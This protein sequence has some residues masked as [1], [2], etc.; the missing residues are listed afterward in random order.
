MNHS[1]RFGL[2]RSVYS[3]LFGVALL[4]AGTALS[5]PKP[6]VADTCSKPLCR[7]GERYRADSNPR[8]TTGWC[9]SSSGFP[10]FTRSH[11]ERSCDTGWTL[12]RTRGVCVKDNCC[13]E[14]PLCSRGERYTRSGTRDGRTY[15][16][17]E[18]R[19]GTYISHTINYCES[20][21]EL[22]TRTGMCKK[23]GCA[24]AI[25]GT[26][27]APVPVFVPPVKGAK[28]DLI[29][30]RF[31]LKDWG[32]CKPGNAVIRFGVTVKNI[33]SAASPAIA[34]KALVKVEDTHS[35]W[36]NGVTVPAIPPGGRQIVEVP[37]Y[38]LKSDPRHMTDAAPHPFVANADPLRL[39]DELREDNNRSSIINVGAPRACK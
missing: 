24:V 19:S 23:Q 17:C 3:L 31:A 5:Y 18:S 2:L 7:S 29:I 9:H 15:G 34:G 12:D 20:G 36:S 27:V 35:A 1:L 33:G 22:N 10:T 30:E 38:Y 21:W 39:V 26:I 6:A 13:P 16:A 37:I 11:Q 14:K 8:A 32:S 4:L 28:P 25:T